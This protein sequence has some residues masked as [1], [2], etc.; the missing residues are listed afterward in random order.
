MDLKSAVRARLMV[1]FALA[2]ACTDEHAGTGETKKRS[3]SED[4]GLVL[5][6][7]D[8][9]ITVP[10]VGRWEASSEIVVE[11]A[12]GDGRLRL[13]GRDHP[14]VALAASH[15]IGREWDLNG[16]EWNEMMLGLIR[17]NYSKEPYSLLT[18]SSS[19]SISDEP[20]GAKC[21]SFRLEARRYGVPPEPEEPYRLE[22]MIG[23]V[24]SAS[25]QPRRIRTL[26]RT[27]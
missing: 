26:R 9:S 20:A 8:F 4:S 24:C 21:A 18:F 15:N 2:T 3:A 5:S 13:V 12:D 17:R 27:P 22:T 7:P 23:W 16:T 19:L 14:I 11:G 10:P 1:M 6:L 25:T